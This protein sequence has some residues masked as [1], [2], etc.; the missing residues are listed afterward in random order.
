MDQILA[1]FEATQAARPG[2]LGP[3]A[4]MG[5]YYQFYNRLAFLHFL[6]E[7]NG[8][9]ARLLFV[10]FLG[11]KFPEGRAEVCPETEEEWQPALEEIERTIGWT[12]GNP[13]ADHVHKLFLPVCP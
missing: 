11:D 6:R 7:Q 1:A 4:W 2:R 10:Y 5:P 13:L 12:A 3:H 9:P 8:I